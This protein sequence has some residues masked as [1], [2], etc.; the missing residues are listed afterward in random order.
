MARG[1][2]KTGFGPSKNILEE[3]KL[4]RILHSLPCAFP[5]A[6]HP[7][8]IPSP[9]PV[10]AA[11]GASQPLS[12]PILISVPIPGARSSRSIP[13][14][15]A[16]SEPSRD[17][18]DPSEPSFGPRGC[19]HRHPAARAR[20]GSS[21]AAPI[22]PCIPGALS[23]S[24]PAPAL[25]A[26]CCRSPGAP[27]APAAPG[28]AAPNNG[29]TGLRPPIPFR[30]RSPALQSRS[31]RAPPG[32]G[33]APLSPRWRGGHFTQSTRRASRAAGVTG[34]AQPG[35]AAHSASPR[36]APP[37]SRAGCPAPRGPPGR[38]GGSAAAPPP[39]RSP[40][41]LPA[42]AGEVTR[43]G[44]A[45]EAPPGPLSSHVGPAA[46]AMD[47]SGAAAAAGPGVP[48]LTPR[49]RQLIPTPCGPIKP[50]SELSFPVKIYFCVTILS[51]LSVIGLT[52]ETL[53]RQAEEDFTI[54]FIQLVGAVFCVYYVSRGILQEN[55]QELV[56]FVLSVL[57]LMLRSIINFSLLPAGQ[58]PQLLAR[59]VL[60]LLVGSFDVVC[61]LVLM[62][63]QSMMAF[64]VGGALESLQAQYFMLNLCF[65]ML[66][67]D[68][69]AQND[70]MQCL[71]PQLCLCI[72]LI[73]LHEVTL[74][75]NILSATGV[76]WGCLKV[77]VGI[78]A[79]L[80]ELKPLVWVFL[81]QNVPEVLYLIYLLC[82]VIR[83][84]GKGNSYTLEAAFITGSCISVTIKSVLLWA[85]LHVYRSFGQG[86]RERM[87]SSYGRIDS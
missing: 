52:I 59:F 1:L 75:H 10:P 77:T 35:T 37:S 73:S 34:H 9:S 32:P 84:W 5:T 54:S 82:T 7:H 28:W 72:L 17:H 48:N 26:R 61:A 42:R 11:P 41:A 68:L 49:H 30:A 45:P 40:A 67:F 56:V 44:P 14:T 81:V 4:Q 27:T 66:T 85:L 83:E 70:S 19:Q 57:L 13:R 46:A 20:L 51:L 60:I 55:R 29:S 15:A 43:G 86:L 63:S 36:A 12:I 24:R 62:Q 33:L 21:P 80:K 76:L 22:P 38:R 79:I 31:G 64:R 58:Q 47:G 2:Q 6:L 8:P 3:E 39:G 71:L 50:C 18:R 65:S 16:A 74:L 25:R 53:V 23:A 69:Q 78:T 87:F